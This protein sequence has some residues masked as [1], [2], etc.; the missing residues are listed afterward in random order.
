MIQV[1]F[2]FLRFL[3][4]V[5]TQKLV[6]ILI[7]I[8]YFFGFGLFAAHVALAETRVKTRPQTAMH[9]HRRT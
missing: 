4:T 7:L 8:G 2:I 6:A 5:I 3:A 1:L 9:L